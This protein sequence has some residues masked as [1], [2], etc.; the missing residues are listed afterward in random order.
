MFT[1]HCHPGQSESGKSTTIKNFQLQYAP[2]SFWAERGTWKKVIHLNLVRSIR[3]IHN[4]LSSLSLNESPI[5]DVSTYSP[6][7]SSSILAL[8]LNNTEEDSVLSDNRFEQKSGP[9]LSSKHQLLLMRLRPILDLDAALMH[10]LMY[11]NSD[12]STDRSGLRAAPLYIPF[13]SSSSPTP[14]RPSWWGKEIP[15]DQPTLCPPVSG[16]SA[17]SS[18][19]GIPPR[20]APSMVL[21]TSTT[22]GSSL[23][24]QPGDEPLI[25][26]SLWSNRLPSTLQ[27][28]L[29]DPSLNLKCTQ[30]L[31][32][33]ER[34]QGHL[35][36]NQEAEALVPA[37]SESTETTQPSALGPVSRKLSSSSIGSQRSQRS[38]S[39]LH[40]SLRKLS[41]PSLAA[42]GSERSG[43]PTTPNKP[44][45]GTG[46]GLASTTDRIMA[47]CASDIAD[48]WKDSIIRKTLDDFFGIRVESEAG[49]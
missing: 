13:P 30:G 9:K 10:Q 40:L 19:T 24:T 42:N 29:E 14:S 32:S 27:T 23:S 26:A 1:F 4:A 44:S 38:T 21:P 18:T 45:F 11:S 22:F 33:S 28:H 5:Q 20:Q 47:A 37:P 16:A 31:P 46:V 3:R 41:L 7:P 48:L 17:P 2:K 36:V 43:S 39:S 34:L 15:D 25:Y 49:L 12:H 35:T 8:G 6:I